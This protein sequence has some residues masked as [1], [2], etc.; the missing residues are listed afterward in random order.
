MTCPGGQ[1]TRWIV[2][3]PE[4][5]VSWVRQP[6]KTQL[7]SRFE[8]RLFLLLDWFPP[9]AKEPGFALLFKP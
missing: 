9:K 1:I 4:I 3:W 7:V 5:G 2:I 8:F 6:D